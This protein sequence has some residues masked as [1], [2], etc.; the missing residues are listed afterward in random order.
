MSLYVLPYSLGDGWYRTFKPATV[1]LPATSADALAHG[2]SKS[3]DCDPALGYWHTQES[4]GPS[5]SKPLSLFYTAGGQPAGVRVD[6]WGHA[7]TSSIGPAAQPNLVKSGF[8]RCV[9]DC[10]DEHWYIVVSTREAGPAM[11][12]GTLMH[13]AVGDRLEVNQDAHLNFS[14]PLSAAAAK[15]QGYAPGS[16]METMG[17][18]WF[19]DLKLKGGRQ[20]WVEGDLL[21]IVPMYTP[22]ADSGSSA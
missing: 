17:Q 13:G 7:Y 9:G 2:W 8:W 15:E 20:G 14:L 1:K 11:C 21:P 16:C 3:D 10:A 18:H 6:I 22:P 12:D 19:L 5:K 4:S